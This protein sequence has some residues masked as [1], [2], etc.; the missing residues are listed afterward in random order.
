MTVSVV[1]SAGQ[2]LEIAGV[3]VEAASLQALTA[4]I[5]ALTAR[6]AALEL[7]SA[8]VA[9]AQVAA[10][11]AV[12][13]AVVVPA[14][15]TAPAAD[16]V[17]EIKGLLESLFAIALNTD[18]SDTEASEIQFEAFRTL[19]HTDRQ[20]SPL[21]NGELRRYKW[22]PFLGRSREYLADVSRPASFL[23]DRMAP[24]KID[25]RTETVKVHVAVRSGRR[26]SPPVTFRRDAL[27]NGAFRIE[28]MSL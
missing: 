1:E 11:V 14:L 23:V 5:A 3:S 26:M 10:P 28:S 9:V 8:L 24:D 13:V 20:G 17:A 18:N 12:A 27:A 4:Q 7:A 19:V 22:Q 16:S 15:N 25:A 21:L 2:T 6:V